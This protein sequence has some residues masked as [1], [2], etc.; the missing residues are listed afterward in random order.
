LLYHFKSLH[1]SSF[2]IEI[3]KIVIAG[4]TGLIGTYLN[5]RFSEQSDNVLIVSRIKGHV[6]W[7]HQEL[8][9]AL[10]GADLLINLAGKTIN[11]RHTTKNKAAILKSRIETTDILGKAVLACNNPPRLWINA[12]ASAIYSADVKEPAIES[13]TQLAND[14]LA[15][16]VKEWEKKFFSFQLSQT[17]Q[18]ALR[19]SV[20]LSSNGG[21]FVPL[22]LLT[23]FGLGGKQGSGNQKFSWIH[24]ED[25]YRLI[26]F[27]MNNPLKGIINCT[28]PHP[29]SNSE[30]MLAFRKCY[31]VKFGLPA[32]AFAIKIGAA[33]IGTESSLLSNSSWLYPQSLLNSNFEFKFPFIENAITDLMYK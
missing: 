31:G 16:V 10:E 18:L 19:T 22:S 27:L 7:N 33:I 25:Y 13:S 11:C 32:P 28:S 3:M 2:N 26:L 12:S 24:I 6:S 30:L 9:N 17:R 14:F 29:I 1:L 21:A 23:K 15:D 5:D 8:I 20:V 4:G